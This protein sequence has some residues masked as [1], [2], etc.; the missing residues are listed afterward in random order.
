MTGQG[1]ASTGQDSEGQV[2][3]RTGKYKC[4]TRQGSTSTGQYREV[5]VQDKT[6]KDEYRT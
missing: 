4:R 2:E 3:D 5:Q 1:R 6:V